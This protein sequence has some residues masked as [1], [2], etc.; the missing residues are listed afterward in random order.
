MNN[1]LDIHTKS[2][3]DLEYVLNKIEV[4]TPYGSE[5]KDSIKPF[6]IG[7]ETHLIEELNRIETFIKLIKENRFFF[8]NIKNIFCH[9][10]DIRSSILR[11][12]DG[13]TLSNVELFEVKSFILMLRELNEELDRFKQELPGDM[14]IERIIELEKTFDPQNTNIKTFYIYDE[15]SEKLQLIRA[16][17]K[18]LDRKLK[19]EKKQLRERIEK[20]LE[21]NI[22]PDGSITVSKDISEL[23]QKLASHPYLVY[24]SE[25]Y[26][27]IKYSLKSTPSI[28]A[29]EKEL[30]TLKE[31]EEKEEFRIRTNLSNEIASYSKSIAENM[32]AIGILDLMMA[33][34]Y[35]AIKIDGVKPDIV[36]DH[37]VDIVEGR[38][39]KVEENLKTKAQVFTPISVTLR[40][41]VTCITGAN[42]GGK[43][44]S[45]KLIGL[46]CAMAQYGIFIPCRRMKMGLHGFIYGS[47]GDM[48]STDNGLSTFGAEIRGIEEGLKR[49]DDRGLILIDELARGTN[50]DEGYA[51][52][53][54]I[55]SYL[56]KR[57]CITLITTHY[58]NIANSDDVNHLQVVG[59]ANVDYNKLKQEL[60]CKSGCRI[61][62]VSKFMDYRL[63]QV[64][65]NA[66]VPRDAINIARLMGLKEEILEEAE[67]I[68]NAEY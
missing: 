28:D 47:I 45:L 39:L 34:A 29:F 24:S 21:V 48:Q 38:H 1:F 60:S 13:Y 2:N 16:Q 64:T 36:E 18:A 20:E 22:R 35:M 65:N 26:M 62:L 63:I 7:E 15:Y 4:C 67:N 25:T 12:N 3:I 61:D 27:S 55:V 41:G 53:K 59:L 57:N 6:S 9:I 58:D 19:L 54:A 52:S 14:R 8:V 30:E 37:I 11:S 33:K 5:K 66:K 68:L 56:N 51:I 31:N 17:K 32:K 43:T 44:V 50:P 42:M 40:E 23:T 49:A 10:K 46:L